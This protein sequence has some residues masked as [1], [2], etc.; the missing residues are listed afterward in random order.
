MVRLMLILLLVSNITHAQ[1]LNSSS[2]KVPRP[3]LVVGIVV[4]QMRWDYLYRYYNRY[5][6]DGGFKRMLNQGYSCE[7][8]MINYLPSFTACG[9]TCIYSGSVPAIHGI[10]GNDWYDRTE[11][12]NRYCV[13]DA[14]VTGVGTTAK[15]G[16]MSPRNLKTTTVCDE[17]RLATNFR[18]KVIGIAIKDRG[19][20]LP[21]G[22]TANAAYWFEG[23]T[24]HWITSSYY[25]QSL[26][27][28]ITDFD[29]KKRI[30]EYF[31]KGWNTLY[32][33][34]TYDQST[35]DDE[36]YE[37]KPFGQDQK[38]F[39][40]HLKEFIDKNY[41]ITPSTPY[42]NTMTKDI[43]I[44]AVNGEDLGQ[45]SITDFLAL[46]FSSTDYIGHEFGPNS[47][48]AEDC[49]LRLDKDI[50]DLFRFLDKKVGKG[51]YVAF[52]SADHGVAHAAGFAEE[53]KLPGGTISESGFNHTLDS[54]LNKSFGN[55][56]FILGTT[57]N[58]ITLDNNLID[59]IK[60]DRPA[61]VKTL[62]DFLASMQGVDRAFELSAVMN[63]PLQEVVRT[64]SV[65]G[66]YPSRSGDIQIL[67][68]PGWMD[69]N[70]KGTT[71]GAWNPYDTH[72][73]LVWYGWNIK[74]GRTNREIYMTDIAP[75]I[76][77]M[78]RIQMPSGA[79]GKPIEELLR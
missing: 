53:N 46:S 10:T 75:T 72:I 27:K 15:T 55:H 41:G 33:I 78:L 18:S 69:G 17:L 40:Y 39:P 62:I 21:A 68:T 52:L 77:A 1:L 31:N 20:I 71:H 59:S 45:D 14:S 57:N 29:S 36:S 4:D 16:Q 60:A 66:Y 67:F 13:E 11:N 70:G 58:Q 22:H 61:I 19:G 37:G 50:G 9:H 63:I 54:L 12:R 51:Q 23:A 26:P 25:E 7:N 38:T 32:P 56:K 44:A 42:G 49:Y 43:A 34:N 5:A 74:H 79:V 2:S 76:S 73:P 64:K 47:I 8:T 6:A 28:W 24:G 65:N 30:D 35:K 48:E 3:K